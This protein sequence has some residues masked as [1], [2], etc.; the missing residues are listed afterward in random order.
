MLYTNYKQVAEIVLNSDNAEQT[1]TSTENVGT[2]ETF[3]SKYKFKVNLLNPMSKNIKIAV[4]SFVSHND[5]ISSD[6]ARNIGDVYVDNWYDKN[7]FNT[8]P[9]IQ[10]KFQLLS[11]PLCTERIDKYYN[12]DIINTS[13]SVQNTAF[14]NSYIDVVVDAKITNSENK[15]IKGI[16]QKNKWSLT[17]VIYD[18]EF[19]ENPKA[20]NYGKMPI[21][22]PKIMDLS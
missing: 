9:S 7:A 19:E 15:V 6:T 16:P 1:N 13:K 11:Y 18:T 5:F 17:L 14:M 20:E 8:D 21:M 22:P 2:A 4:K 12:N 10:N 3:V